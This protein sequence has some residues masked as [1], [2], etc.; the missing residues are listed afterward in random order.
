MEPVYKHAGR[1]E[2]EGRLLISRRRNLHWRSTNY[3]NY[4]SKFEELLKFLQE[5]AVRYMKNSSCSEC[6]GA[7]INRVGPDR[8]SERRVLHLDGG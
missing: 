1:A 3:S 6:S 7:T 2:I 8:V 4:I 5:D